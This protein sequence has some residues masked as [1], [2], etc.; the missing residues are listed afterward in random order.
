MNQDFLDLYDRAGEWTTE[1]VAGA[2]S[3]LDAPTPCDEWNVRALMNHMLET[4]RYFVSAARGQ[5]A[6]PPAASPP[7]LLSNQ[8]RDD[9][10]RLRRDGLSAYGEPGVIEKTGVSLGIA[11]S[12]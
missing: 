12:D 1:K 11:F 2:T 3:K 4:Q 7:E 6:S 8:P 5:D 9:F 10:A